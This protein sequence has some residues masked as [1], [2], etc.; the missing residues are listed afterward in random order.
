MENWWFAGPSDREGLRANFFGKTHQI[1]IPSRELTYP[2]LGSSE[3][4]L[5]NAIFLGDMWSFPGGYIAAPSKRCCLN[6]PKGWCFSASLGRS[7]QKPLGRKIQVGGR[8]QL[9]NQLLDDA[10]RSM[11]PKILKMLQAEMTEWWLN[12]DTYLSWIASK[13]PPSILIKNIS[14]T[15]LI[16][17]SERLKERSSSHTTFTKQGNRLFG[18]QVG[19]N[20][21]LIQVNLKPRMK[22]WC[23]KWLQTNWDDLKHHCRGILSIVAICAPDFSF[24]MVRVVH[25]ILI[26]MHTKRIAN[27]ETNTFLILCI[28]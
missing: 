9:P 16:L 6:L 21:L 15:E 3:N 4:H 24:L 12:D 23:T 19:K 17:R 18:S 22:C 13:G 20:T 2:T 5:Q 10:E 26:L 14:R 25:I 28:I 27:K 1:Y 11:P 7:I 8:T